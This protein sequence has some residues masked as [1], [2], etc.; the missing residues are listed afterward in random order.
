MKALRWVWLVRAGVVLVFVVVFLNSVLWLPLLAVPALPF[1]VLV[2]VFALELFERADPR[3][4]AVVA[5]LIAVPTLL[6]GLFVP[7]ALPYGVLSAATAF[8]SGRHRGPSATLPE[9][10]ALRSALTR[11]G[12]RREVLGAHYRWRL[13]IWLAP[14]V[15]L[16]VLALVMGAA[17]AIS[18]GLA[19]MM[20]LVL[21][22][23]LQAPHELLM[24]A[25]ALVLGA[26]VVI[27]AVLGAFAT[28]PV[29]RLPAAR[30]MRASWP[31]RGP[32]RGGGWGVA[33]VLIVADLLLLAGMVA[34]V[35]ATAASIVAPGLVGGAAVLPVVAAAAVLALRLTLADVALLT[36][37]GMIGA[38]GTALRLAWRHPGAVTRVTAA[39]VFGL[40]GIAGGCVAGTVAVVTTFEPFLT[41]RVSDAAADRVLAAL[42]CAAS[43]LTLYVAAP[44]LLLLKLFRV[45]AA[46]VML[47]STAPTERAQDADPSG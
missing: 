40:S 13:T 7:V 45:A 4:T 47:G 19:P 43:G 44:A 32:R 31:E 5:A 38:S 20:P 11:F 34:L 29:S 24:G 10:L 12:A 33:A 21:I 28:T 37:D 26:V 39:W 22:R 46:D 15:A 1:L 17:V 8:A 18:M 16:I 6:A 9:V 27:G 14:H 42:V 3:A 30:L 35:L 2:A 23:G 25:G 41:G 36:G